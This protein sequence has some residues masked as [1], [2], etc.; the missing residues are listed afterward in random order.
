MKKSFSKIKHLQHAN[1]ILENRYLSEKKSFIF[2]SPRNQN[3]EIINEDGI[4]DTVTSYGDAAVNWADENL[5]MDN[6][7]WYLVPGAQGVKATRDQYK[8]IR[9][10]E[11]A[12]FDDWMEGIRDFL[13]GIPGTMVTVALDITGVGEVAEPILWSMMLAYDCY[14]WIEKGI[15]NLLDII[16]DSISVITAGLGAFIGKTVKALKKEATMT[17][18]QLPTFIKWIKTNF[19]KFFPYFKSFILNIDKII[20]TAS[21]NASLGVKQLIK[22]FP[23]WSKFLSLINK[24]ITVMPNAM[25]SI[26][27]KL[28]SVFGKELAKIPAK[29]LDST[30]S[31]VTDKLGI[32]DYTDY[33]KDPYGKTKKALMKT[34]LGPKV[35]PNLKTVLQGNLPKGTKIVDSDNGK[36][37]FI[38]GY[39]GGNQLG[40]WQDG[41]VLFWNGKKWS[42]GGFWDYE[43]VD[44]NALLI[45]GWLK[46]KSNRNVSLSVALNNPYNYFSDDVTDSQK[47]Y[48]EQTWAN[49]KQKLLSNKPA[50]LKVVD[51]DNK[52]AYF[53]TGYSD[54]KQL[55]F[56]KDGSIK[57][58]DGKKWSTKP[59]KW[60]T[61]S[62][63]E[64][65]EL[66]GGWLTD[67]T[68]TKVSLGPAINNAYKYFA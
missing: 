60:D 58:W 40:F 1:I 52:Q 66:I 62:V 32:S 25:G 42:K 67:K 30:I 14:K 2:E 20:R 16:M 23:K 43:S 24:G 68:G 28:E 3:L 9:F 18:E 22:K 56:W 55:G 46:D 48:T 27:K 65:G 29:A 7:L 26:K 44:K 8:L 34:A 11:T 15:L 13:G 59:G 41:R 33:I 38:T 5:A 21:V 6:D 10:A 39:Q 61:K 19:P 50:T 36:A 49:L 12:T 57:F 63:N 17:L 37:Y 45:G 64:K 31:L 4:W 35:W 51:S 47:K 53:I 54:N